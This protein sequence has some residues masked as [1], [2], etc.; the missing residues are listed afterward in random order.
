MA[1]KKEYNILVDLKML[2]DCLVKTLQ[3]KLQWAKTLTKEK[4]YNPY[5]YFL[6]LK[7]YVELQPFMMKNH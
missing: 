4:E 2:Y 7:V 5:D 6:P 3:R 1:K